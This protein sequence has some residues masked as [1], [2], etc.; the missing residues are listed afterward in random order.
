MAVFTPPVSKPAENMRE[1]P[2]VPWALVMPQFEETCK[3]IAPL[4]TGAAVVFP[5]TIVEKHVYSP[6]TGPWEKARILAGQDIVVVST[7]FTYRTIEKIRHTGFCEYL[8][9]KPGQPT[10]SWDFLTCPAGNLAD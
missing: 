5:S 4:P 9:P 7:C 1:V 2:D 10:S 8:A 6:L 3:A